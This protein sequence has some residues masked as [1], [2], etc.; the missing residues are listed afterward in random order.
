MVNNY[1]CLRV[2][3][4]LAQ[5]YGTKNHP[6]YIYTPAYLEYSAG[7][8]ALHYLCHSLN[9]KGYLSW[10]IIHGTNSPENLLVNANLNTPIL[11]NELRDAHF[12]SGLVPIVVYPETIPGNPLKAQVVVRWVLN[13][14]GI[15][16]GPEAFNEKEHLVAYSTDIAKTARANTPVL[17]LPPL[18]IR[19]IHDARKL[20]AN[21]ARTDRVLLYAGKYRGYVGKPILPRW[22]QTE[23]TEIW[24]EGPEKQTREEVLELLATSSRVFI[25]EN[26]TLITEAVLL[27]TPVILVK[28]TFFES[29]IAEYELGD[30]G[31][32][33]SDQ[34]DAIEIAS[35]TIDGAEQQYLKAVKNFFVDLEKEV[36]VW[37]AM[38]SRSDYLSPILLP[39]SKILISEHRI[40]LAIQIL[41]SQGLVTLFRVI[42][43]FLK[44][45]YSKKSNFT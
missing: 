30:H 19:E 29:L 32:A 44:R 11:N 36:T 4:D 25:F 26:S 5:L 23:Y 22:A 41:K 42:R 12:K 31:T 9:Q 38:A 17:F 33:W 10:L 45:R 39:D 7:V 18:D 14:L 35:A 20:S 27:G 6:I 34:K 28:S 16:G 40:S 43:S 37:L 1:Y 8:R 2:N 3:I 21:I 13:H 24:R 15:L